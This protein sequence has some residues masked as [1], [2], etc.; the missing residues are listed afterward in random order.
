VNGLGKREKKLPFM[1]LYKICLEV[2]KDVTQK[3]NAS[4][5]EEFL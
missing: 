4:R 2:Y 3:K 1:T 5:T